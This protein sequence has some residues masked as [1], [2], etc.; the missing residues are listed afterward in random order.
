MNYAAAQLRSSTDK[1]NAVAAAGG[2]H[3]EAAFARFFK[4]HMGVSPGEYRNCRK[5]GPAGIAF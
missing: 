3:S 4:R 1:V 5:G 2:Y